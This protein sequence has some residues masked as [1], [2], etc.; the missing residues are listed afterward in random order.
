MKGSLNKVSQ[1]FVY[2][3]YTAGTLSTDVTNDDKLDKV[4]LEKVHTFCYLGNIFSAD[5]GQQ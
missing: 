2:K 3:R 1:S 5:G 4:L